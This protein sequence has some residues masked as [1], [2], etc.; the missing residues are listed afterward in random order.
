MTDLAQFLLAKQWSLN[1]F[2]SVDKGRAGAAG[3][4]ET[5]AKSDRNSAV[6]AHLSAEAQ[7]RLS[8]QAATTTGLLDANG[9]GASKTGASKTGASGTGGLSAST[10]DTL[11]KMNEATKQSATQRKDQA[12]QRVQQL[13]EQ[14]KTL[15]MLG[16]V[17]ARQLAEIA[18]E[19]KAAVKDFMQAG[20]SAADLSA[21]GSPAAGTPVPG[22]APAAQDGAEAS[23][24]ADPKAEVE[25]KDQGSDPEGPALEAKSDPGDVVGAKQAALEAEA[26]AA[27]AKAEASDQA[28]DTPQDRTQQTPPGGSVPAPR[29]STDPGQSNPERVAAADYA[30]SQP[31]RDALAPNVDKEFAKLVREVVKKIQDLAQKAKVENKDDVKDLKDNLREVQRMNAQIDGAEP[32]GLIVS[33][34]V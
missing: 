26:E 4:T 27:K 32:A 9:P 29:L 7:K 14:L 22:Q 33:T 8:D 13:I 18:K 17:T 5:A 25:A 19:L 15:K 20:G 3:R 1:P 21:G 2:P 24:Q 12:K 6:M 10:L 16:G 28:Q 11:K 34:V 31:G 30:R 23:G